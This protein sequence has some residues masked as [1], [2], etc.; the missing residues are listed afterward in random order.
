MTIKLNIAHQRQ[1]LVWHINFLSSYKKRPSYKSLKRKN[2]LYNLGRIW[3]HQQIPFVDRNLE[4]NVSK[5]RYFV[6]KTPE[7]MVS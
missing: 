3:S 1:V 4:K 2:V 6:K 7:I 5:D